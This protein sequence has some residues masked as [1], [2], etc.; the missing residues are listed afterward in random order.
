MVLAVA[1]ALSGC[2]TEPE[3]IELTPD[4]QAQQRRIYFAEQAKVEA[5]QAKV[6]AEQKALQQA[7]LRQL[8]VND[9][10]WCRSYGAIPGSGIYVQCRM[11][12]QNQRNQEEMQHRANRAALVR[13]MFQPAR[14]CVQN[15]TI[16]NCY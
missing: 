15:G 2:A 16:T 3:R 9:D 7:A 14:T 12:R 5:Q 8:E 4:Q 13:A 6:A 11:N 1:L 10:S